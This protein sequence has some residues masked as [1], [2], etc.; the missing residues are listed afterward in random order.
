V[1]ESD[2]ARLHEPVIDKEDLSAKELVILKDI[3]SAEDRFDVGELVEPTL[4]PENGALA[5]NS[6][7]VSDY[8]QA[9]G[10]NECEIE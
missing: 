9:I 7:G 4:D 2:S 6:E 8:A 1:S 3:I 5:E 10:K